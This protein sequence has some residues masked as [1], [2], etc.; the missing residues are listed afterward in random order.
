MDYPTF[1]A[2][3]RSYR[4]ASDRAYVRLMCLLCEIHDTPRVWKDRHPTFRD[5]LR[6]ERICTV[7]RYEAFRKARSLNLDVAKLGVEA[8]CL[9]AKYPPPLRTRALRATYGWISRHKVRPTY[10]LVAEYVKGLA[11]PANKRATK[12]ELRR[13]IQVLQKLCLKHGLNFPLEPK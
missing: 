11:P 9:L 13:Y 7:S 5:V 4:K 3:A 10:Q 12:A 2:T 8:S 1:V 6:V